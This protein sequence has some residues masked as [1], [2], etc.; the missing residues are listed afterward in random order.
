MNNLSC[1]LWG[2][3]LEWSHFQSLRWLIEF[4]LISSRAI[5]RPREAPYISGPAGGFGYKVS[6]ALLIQVYCHNS[7]IKYLVLPGF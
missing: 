5:W 7:G 4:H 6:V 3:R 1:A 2:E